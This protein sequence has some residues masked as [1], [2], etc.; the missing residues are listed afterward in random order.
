MNIFILR[1]GIAVDPGTAGY[2]DDS[3]RPLVPK[4]ERRLEKAAGAM[5]KLELSFDLIVSSPYLRARQTAEIVAA[6]LKLKKRLQFSDHLVPDGDFEALIRELNAV[7][8]APKDLLLVGHEPHLSHFIGFLCS[9]NP[10]ATIEMKKGG[11]CKMEAERLLPGHCARL[12]WL[13]TPSQM[14]L[15]A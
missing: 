13:L 5:K 8:P 14:E 12:A 9:G 4:G 1:H 6:E 10:H 11:L 15:M 7:K 2:E 3:Q